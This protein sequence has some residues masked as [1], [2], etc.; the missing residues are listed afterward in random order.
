MIWDWEEFTRWDN[1]MTRFEKECTAKLMAEK[2]ILRLDFADK[3]YDHSL[4]GNGT[5]F[6]GNR[7]P[8]RR[9]RHAKGVGLSVALKGLLP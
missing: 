2:D 1:G 6:W 3:R 9:I 4:S 5:K 7:E 8:G